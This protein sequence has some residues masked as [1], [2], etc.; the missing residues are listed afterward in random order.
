MTKGE[1]V[2]KGER[3]Q[4][5]NNP[6]CFKWGGGGEGSR[7]REAR[8]RGSTEAWKRTLQEG[9]NDLEPYMLLRG[10][11]T[12]IYGAPNIHEDR[13]GVVQSVA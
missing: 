5:W 2:D 4:G 10:N 7:L 12:N 8:A 3:G 6:M 11:S 9:G 13:H 1:R